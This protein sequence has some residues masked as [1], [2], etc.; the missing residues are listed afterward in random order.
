MDFGSLLQEYDPSGRFLKSSLALANPRCSSSRAG[1]Q[2][3]LSLQWMPGTFVKRPHNMDPNGSKVEPRNTMEQC[4][5]H[6]RHNRSP[7]ALEAIASTEA[8]HRGLS[9]SMDVSPQLQEASQEQVSCSPFVPISLE[10]LIQ[11][12]AAA[13][14]DLEV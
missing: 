5:T 2:P 10:T 8:Y 12:T 13:L 7:P 1:E 6:L 14:M 11:L 9:E 3:D 4:F